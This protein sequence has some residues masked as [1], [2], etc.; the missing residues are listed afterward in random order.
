MKTEGMNALND[1][2]G[3][4]SIKNNFHIGTYLC[5]YRKKKPNKTG[6]GC[7]YEGP[8][9]QH[10]YHYLAINPGAWIHVL[11]DQ[12]P[13]HLRGKKGSLK[14]NP[15]FSNYKKNYFEQLNRFYF[16]IKYPQKKE[17]S[18]S[19]DE[20]SFFSTDNMV[21]PDQNDESINSLWIGYWSGK[22]FWEIGFQ[23]GSYTTHN[24][25]TNSTYEIRWSTSPI[26]NENFEVATPINARF[27]SGVS[28]TG[29]RGT[30]LIRRQSGW[31]ENAWTR[32]ELPD[33]VEQN[34]LKVFFAVKDV[35]V[36]GKH[37]GTGWPYNKGDGHD[38]PTTNIKII[39]YYL[40]SPVN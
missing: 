14:N 9:N 7:P 26:T 12:H 4:S 32:F 35:S 16:D 11:L 36:K 39:D 2:G 31:R 28:V 13:Q 1:D 17:T 40:K 30:S 6:D 34:Y 33:E 18:L 37:I 38:A 25:T 22:D 24:D 27:Y 19:I 20:L 10:Y 8:G 15:T 3:K 23:D 29:V 21:E 5:W